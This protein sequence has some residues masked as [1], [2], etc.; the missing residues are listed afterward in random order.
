MVTHQVSAGDL[1][2]L[3]GVAT[4]SP[5]VVPGGTWHVSRLAAGAEFALLGT[6]EWGAFAA[7]ELELGDPVELAGRYPAFAERLRAAP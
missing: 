1:G 7:E 6:T 4:D 3:G 5:V 2:A